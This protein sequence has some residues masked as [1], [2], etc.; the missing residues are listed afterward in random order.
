MKCTAQVIVTRSTSGNQEAEQVAEGALGTQTRLL[1]AL[2]P[3]T[4][5]GWQKNASLR[6]S[7]T[8]LR[9]LKYL[10]VYLHCVSNP[11]LNLKE[12]FKVDLLQAHWGILTMRDSSELLREDQ[13]N[14]WV[15]M[16]GGGSGCMWH[17]V[18]HDSKN[19]SMASWI[20]KLLQGN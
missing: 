2:V 19:N 12:L 1:W 17:T 4:C 16:G 10:S 20:H 7:D 14:Y 13:D 8:F 6:S 15:K 5:P 3:P 9:H 11:Y 18:R